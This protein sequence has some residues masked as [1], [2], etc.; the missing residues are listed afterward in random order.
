MSYKM[1]HIFSD[2]RKVL[3]SITVSIPSFLFNCC[4]LTFEKTLIE[5]LFPVFRLFY[6]N[7]IMYSVYEI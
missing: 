3:R 7:P 1:R 2:E 5:V 4:R 6:V